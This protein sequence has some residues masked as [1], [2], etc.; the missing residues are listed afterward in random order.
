M[1]DGPL[2]LL[3][4]SLGQ[5]YSSTAMGHRVEERM[6]RTWLERP[7]LAVLSFPIP[8]F[9]SCLQQRQ[10]HGCLLRVPGVKDA[11]LYLCLFTCMPPSSLGVRQ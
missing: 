5:I 2:S 6:C 7:S 10:W 11:P 8:D 1:A 4:P 3:Q 9:R